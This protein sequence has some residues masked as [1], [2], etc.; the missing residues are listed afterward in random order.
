MREQALERAGLKEEDIPPEGR[1]PDLLKA[2]ADYGRQTAESMAHGLLDRPD[3]Q[4][5]V[6]RDRYERL[7][8]QLGIMHATI[9]ELK[10]ERD[11]Q[12]QA[13]SERLATIEALVRERDLQAEAAEARLAVIEG[14]ERK[15]DPRPRAPDE[16]SALQRRAAQ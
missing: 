2:F 12:A 11:L 10:R 16:L 3:M 15:A 6:V 5:T 8:E 9:E 4:N 7:H 13:A 14:R 1:L